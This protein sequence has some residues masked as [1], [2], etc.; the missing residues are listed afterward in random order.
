M[1]WARWAACIGGDVWG[2][3]IAVLSITHPEEDLRLVQPRFHMVVAGIMGLITGAVLGSLVG[4]MAVALVGTVLGCLVGMI[5]RRFCHG[6]KWLIFRIFPEGPVVRRGVRS[7]SSGI[8]PGLDTSDRRALVWQSGRIGKWA[9]LL[10]CHPARRV[11]CGRA[12]LISGLTSGA[13]SMPGPKGRPPG[14]VMGRRK[15]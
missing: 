15:G 5:L 11:S 10:F 7:S 4:I 1:P 2:S 3:V 6:K 9:V 8:L 12:T 13:G 14:R